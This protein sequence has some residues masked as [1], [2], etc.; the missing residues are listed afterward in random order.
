MEGWGGRRGEEGMGASFGWKA[1]K[2]EVDTQNADSSV[3]TVW[4]Y[5][6]TPS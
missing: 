4:Y 3:R 2:D 6:F 1:E 5:G